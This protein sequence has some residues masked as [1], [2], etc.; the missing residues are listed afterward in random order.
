MSDQT[1]QD[2]TEAPSA[3]GPGLAAPPCSEFSEA[4]L[5]DAQHHI[6]RNLPGWPTTFGPCSRKCGSGLNGRGGGPCLRCAADDL[7][8]LVGQ[9]M[10]EKYVEA[11]RG[12]RDIEAAMLDIPNSDSPTHK[13]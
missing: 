2:S 6:W 12:I 8:A 4:K 5:R 9:E 3:E 7:A 10:A 11:V 1:K 13:S